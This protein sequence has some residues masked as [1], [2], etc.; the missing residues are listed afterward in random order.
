MTAPRRRHSFLGAAQ[1]AG[2]LIGLGVNRVVTLDIS[3]EIIDQHVADLLDVAPRAAI[4]FKTL[5]TTV[6]NSGT[7]EI[8][9][10]TANVCV[11]GMLLQTATA[12]EIGQ[13]V[14]FD[15]LAGD[16]DDMVS[17]E[18]SVVR[19]AVTERGGV[20]GIGL[21]FLAFQGDGRKRIEEV[22]M[23]ACVSS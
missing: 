15:F 9:G 21:R 7:I 2:G 12:L 5:L 23:W 13:L 6:L 8:L 11:T 22:L 17:G 19:H 1:E 14:A 3:E 10:R 16:G 4:R 18:A 20:D